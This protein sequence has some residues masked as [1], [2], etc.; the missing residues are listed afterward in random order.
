MAFLVTSLA[1]VRKLPSICLEF[2][3]EVHPS[4]GCREFQ[5]SELRLF[6]I[7]SVLEYGQPGEQ[8]KLVRCS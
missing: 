5:R 8:H 7:V 1:H 6:Y 2:H 3:I 4:S